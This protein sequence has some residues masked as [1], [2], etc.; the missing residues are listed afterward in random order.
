MGY[1]RIICGNP[2][3]FI[4]DPPPRNIPLPNV[5]VDTY[6]EATTRFGWMYTKDM[7]W[8][9]PL[10]AKRLSGIARGTDNNSVQTKQENAKRLHN[11]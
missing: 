6:E 10:C 8:I 11:K 9:C 3:H 5:A 2:N 1:F 7:L 4:D